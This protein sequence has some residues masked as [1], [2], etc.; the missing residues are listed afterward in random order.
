MAEDSETNS[1]TG[2]VAVP[3]ESRSGSKVLVVGYFEAT[4]KN[5]RIRRL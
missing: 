1:S 4:W 2:M 5:R 3:K